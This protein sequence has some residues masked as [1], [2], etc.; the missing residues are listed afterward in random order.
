M[1]VRSKFTNKESKS[2]GTNYKTPIGRTQWED[3]HLLRM[4]IVIIIII[5]VMMIY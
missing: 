4:V 5:M 2:E 1:I 3:G